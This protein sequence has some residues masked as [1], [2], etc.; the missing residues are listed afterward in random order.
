MSRKFF[1]AVAAL[2]IS[3]SMFAQ[4]PDLGVQKGPRT[5]GD[6]LNSENVFMQADGSYVRLNL[7]EDGET[8]DMAD[9][10]NAAS[11]AAE[12]M[13]TNGYTHWVV[14]RNKQ[15]GQMVKKEA[16]RKRHTGWALGAFVGGEYCIDQITPIVGVTLAY[17]GV[18]NVLKLDMGGGIAEYL[19]T[20]AKPGQ[21]YGAWTLKGS[22]EYKV[23]SS[24]QGTL[25]RFY[26]SI[27][28]YVKARWCR[29][30]NYIT[31]IVELEEGST[32]RTDAVD[33]ANITGG[34]QT[35]LSWLISKVSG[36]RLGLT[37]AGGPDRRYKDFGHEI[38][39]FGSA[40]LTLT[41]PLSRKVYTPKV[42]VAWAKAHGKTVHKTAEVDFTYTNRPY[43]QPSK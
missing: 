2:F 28:G 32:P 26:W 7:S 42:G 34:L 37:L 36:T 3:T 20:S 18:R 33:G 22:Y 10:N 21:K 6:L 29:D 14:I 27:G 9:V 16:Y 30:I 35:T 41:V 1:A 25:E 23:W 31:E 12:S 40:T 13:N 43:Q 38:G 24:K 39:P 8:L 4:N 11:V 17:Q 15:T 19:S 5:D